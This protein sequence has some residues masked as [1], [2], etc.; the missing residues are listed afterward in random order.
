MRKVLLPLTKSSNFE[1]IV[2]AMGLEPTTSCLQS[3]CSSQ[4]SYAPGPL[5]GNALNWV[6][7]PT[8]PGRSF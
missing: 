5:G 8:S 7:P 3:R 4:L 2:E 6:R 1:K